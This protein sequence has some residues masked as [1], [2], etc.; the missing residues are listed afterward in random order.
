MHLSSRLG[1]RVNGRGL[2]QLG[3]EGRAEGAAP[4]QIITHGANAQAL[5]NSFAGPSLLHGSS[6]TT[7]LNRWDVSRHGTSGGFKE[8]VHQGCL[9]PMPLPPREIRPGQARQRTEQS[10]ATLPTAAIPGQLTPADTRAGQAAGQDLDQLDPTA[11]EK[12]PFSVVWLF[13]RH[14]YY[15]IC[16]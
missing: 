7:S 13:V 11:R 10:R 5:L 4:G 1:F 9:L 8:F 2:V 14:H 12:Q 16:Q 15:S 3:R 6:P